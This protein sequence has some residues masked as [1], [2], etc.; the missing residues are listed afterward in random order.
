MMLAT[1]QRLRRQQ[2]LFFQVLPE[3]RRT[4]ASI[5]AG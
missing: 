5:R 1:E 3:A 4:S 2:E